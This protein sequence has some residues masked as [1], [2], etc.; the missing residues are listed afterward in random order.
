MY[1]W[2]GETDLNLNKL[3]YLGTVNLKQ[4]YLI[5]PPSAEA[6][7]TARIHIHKILIS[8]QSF[9]LWFHVPVHV[10]ITCYYI[11][12]RGQYEQRYCGFTYYL[13]IHAWAINELF[14][15][16]RTWCSWF[17]VLKSRGIIYIF[18]DIKRKSYKHY[19]ILPSERNKP[20]DHFV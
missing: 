19:M 13:N 17:T 16:L 18:I 15:E 3:H 4:T 7:T 1:L 11:F 9:K 8:F 6:L 12:S 5:N 20:C 10:N 14:W 2:L